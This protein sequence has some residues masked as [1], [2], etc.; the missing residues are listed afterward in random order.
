MKT[1][2]RRTIRRYVWRALWVS[3]LL[4]AYFYGRCVWQFPFWHSAYEPRVTIATSDSTRV[5][6]LATYN[7]ANF[8]GS[9]SIY[10]AA[11][12]AMRMEELGVDILCL[13][14]VGINREFT[15]DSLH[16]VFAAWPHRYVPTAPDGKRLLQ[17]AVFSRYP[18]R[19][20]QLITYPESVNASCRCD[21][22]LG[23]GQIIRLFNNHLQTTAV[24]QNRR[25]IEREL[26][27]EHIQE[28]EEAVE[29]LV[30]SLRSNLKRRNAQA[31]TIHTLIN[32]SPHPVIACGDFNSLPLSY[33]YRTLTSKTLKDGF[34]T[35]GHGYMH[36]YRY[37]KKLLRIDYILHSPTLEGVDYFSPQWAYS[38][39]NPVVMRVRREG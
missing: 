7:V 22:D 38:D 23:G 5:L 36:T 9:R 21:L 11:T 34:R 12:I 17:L 15:V 13:Q 35:C 32:A 3:L 26:N 1:G 20:T 14:E 4:L 27:Q 25:K 24:R 37:Y 18:I 6:T 16:S 39:H 29:E 28:A 2:K 30:G 33:V 10:P 31:D 8:G 19:Q